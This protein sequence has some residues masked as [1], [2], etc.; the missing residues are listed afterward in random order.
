MYFSVVPEEESNDDDSNC[1]SDD[2]A[3]SSDEE[4]TNSLKTGF[5]TKE[6]L[7]LDHRQFDHGKYE[8]IYKWLYYSYSQRGFMCKICTVFHGDKPLLAHGSRG[9]WS[10]RGVVFKE[11]PGKKLRRH[12]SS[13]DHKNAVLAKTNV[14]MEKS[15]AASRDDSRENANELYIGKL[16]QIVQF[17]ARN[18]LPVK[19]IYPKLIDFLANEIQEPIIKQYLE[20]CNKNATYCS[21]ETCDSL[22]HSL[23]QFYFEETRERIQKSEDIVIY[24]DESMSAARKEMLGIFIGSFD[25]ADKDFKM[26]FI[27]L[28][29]VSSTKSEIVMEAVERTL[30]EKEIDI[31]KTRFSCLDGTNSMSGNYLRVKFLDTLNFFFGEIF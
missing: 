10:H 25:E 30:R 5:A 31:S 9:A 12:E 22:I 23:E 8:K 3:N 4:E 24:A 29:E 16:V 18:N 17:L 13:T 26:D 2:I 15:L 6:V 28:T 11:N 27:A 20:T 19:R 1:S 7:R 21:H 14:S